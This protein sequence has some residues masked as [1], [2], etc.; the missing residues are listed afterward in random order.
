[1]FAAPPTSR[2]DT[3]SEAEKLYAEGQFEKSR[4]QFK[5]ALAENPARG[6][7]FFY[8]YG[9]AALQ[10]GATGEAFVALQR[11]TLSAPFDS[12]IQ[13]N[14]RRS[15]TNLPATVKSVQPVS[16]LPWWP[17]TLRAITWKIW[18]LI[19]FLFLAPFL[20]LS[21]N[22]GEVGMGAWGSLAGAMLFLLITGLSAWQS[23]FLAGGIVTTTK[24]L[25][26]PAPTYPGISSLE[27]GAL[28]NVEEKREGWSKL[29]YRNANLQETVGWVESPSVLEFR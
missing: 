19:S 7:A 4:Q 5:T 25:S 10:A 18:L 24:V 15:A 27:A 6:A 21:R 17:P 22:K 26:G 13:N 16:W 12:D 28:V 20:W 11:A 8:N 2:A 23:R 3:A 9:T 14:F 1:L 29:R